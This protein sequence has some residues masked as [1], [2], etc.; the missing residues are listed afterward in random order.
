LFYDTFLVVCAPFA[1]QRFT[2]T[3]LPNNFDKLILVHLFKP[4]MIGTT[5]Q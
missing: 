1:E 3:T 4:D 5:N 2:E